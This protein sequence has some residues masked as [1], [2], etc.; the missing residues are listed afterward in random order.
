MTVWL[1]ATWRIERTLHERPTTFLLPLYSSTN[2]QLFT[3]IPGDGNLS[4]GVE[5]ADYTLWANGFG[6]PDAAFQTGDYNGDG[7]TSA[8][9][10]TLWANNFGIGVSAPS[11]S[12][13]AVP[14][15]ST[16]VLATVGIIGLFCYCR[17]RRREFAKTS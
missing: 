2:L 16:F 13:D 3:A 14:E 9:D 17:L 4:G 10:Y 6:A 7:S 8:A 12:L 1:K 11:S 15:P 5:A